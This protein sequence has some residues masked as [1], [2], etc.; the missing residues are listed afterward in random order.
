MYTQRFSRF[1]VAMLLFEEI[2]IVRFTTLALAFA[3]ANVFGLMSALGQQPTGQAIAGIVFTADERGN[4]ISAIDLRSGK[5]TIVPI[6]VSPHNLQIAASGSRLL[7][8][9]DSSSEAH[10]HASGMSK[11][12]GQLLVFD[13]TQLKSAPVATIEVG[14]HPAHVV[15][16][17]LGRRAFVTSAG[18]NGVTVVD[19]V[20]K[21][22]IRTIPTGRYPH[23]L[24][25]SPDGRE[26]YVANVQDG[27]VSVIDTVKLIEVARVPVGR[28]PVQVGFTPDGRSVYVSLRDENQVAKIDA[29]SRKVTA[30]IEVGRGPIQ[31]HVTPSG[32]FVYVANQ[33]TDADPADTVSVIDVATDRVVET[34]RT[35]KGAHGVAVS[36]DGSHVFVTNIL[37]GTVSVIDAASR[38]VVATFPVGKGPNG[39]TFRP[40]ED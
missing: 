39:I 33:G 8:V 15:A 38:T 11:S 24:R 3:L 23:G 9:G 19:L 4:S 6:A 1:R 25:A 27:N 5:V 21:R 40:A 17:R 10:G 29:A 14:A 35:G 13:P 2:K 36:D 20:Q 16:D 26:I 28:A 30:K 22:K 32:R 31:V 7:A 12:K 18:D 37:D 34:I